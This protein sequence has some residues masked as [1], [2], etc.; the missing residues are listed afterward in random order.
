MSLSP[1]NCHIAYCTLR[2]YNAVLTHAL[3]HIEMY[4]K[5]SFSKCTCLI[6]T[7]HTISMTFEMPI[8]Q[9]VQKI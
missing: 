8:N 6:V 1:V 5:I 9:R 7:H 2:W 4:F 3:N